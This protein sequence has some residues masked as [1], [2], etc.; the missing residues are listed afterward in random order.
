MTAIGNSAIATCVLTLLTTYSLGLETR[1]ENFLPGIQLGKQAAVASPQPV[2]A[3]SPEFIDQQSA[4]L[5]IPTVSSQASAVVDGAYTLGVGDR[6]QLN[7]F[8]VP[9]YSGEHQVLADGSLN[10]LLI[11]NVPVE[12]LTL[13]QAADVIAA[14]YAPLLRHPLVNINL[15]ET[16]QQVTVA[17][18]G[19]ISRPGA[20]S[21][22]ATGGHLPTVTQAL[23]VAGGITSS[24][25]I[26][27]I[28]L[29]RTTASGSNQVVEVDLWQLLQA[30]NLNQDV[31]LRQGDT[32][33]I[34]RANEVSSAASTQL[35]AASFSPDVMQINVLGEVEN[36]GSLELQP[37]T[38]LNQA[39][40]AAGGLNRRARKKSVGLIRLN[41]DGTVTQREIA[42]DVAQAVNEETN[43]ILRNGD[44]LLVGRSKG[45]GMLD[46]F[47]NFLSP[48]G[49]LLGIFSLF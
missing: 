16:S 25:D 33:V 2:L 43:P 26:Q 7:I 20:H 5:P 24:A 28:Q 46:G 8:N 40:L 31:T 19:E 35:A 4:V 12:G 44:V 29:H 6:I 21:L 9:E 41:P 18:V 32:L 14:Q 37:N 48:L 1:T 36:P 15:V 42:L 3:E 45:A 38:P 13:K 23:E 11:G 17:V 49:R 10:L 47:R 27:H 30:G 34:P 39:L 22:P